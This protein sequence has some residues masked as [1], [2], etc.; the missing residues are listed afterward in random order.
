MLISVLIGFDYVSGTYMYSGDKLRQ[1]DFLCL[2]NNRVGDSKGAQLGVAELK[3]NIKQW[4]KG[5][6][7]VVVV[8]VVSSY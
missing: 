8:V 2:Y 6:I 7:I 3:A 1:L 4:K 5:I